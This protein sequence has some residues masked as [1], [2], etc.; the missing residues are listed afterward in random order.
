MI[1]AW[2][3]GESHAPT[4]LPPGHEGGNDSGA[5]MTISGR[6][7]NQRKWKSDAS[8]G[9][10]DQKISSMERVPNAKRS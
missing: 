1:D 3:A 6:L 7:V 5:D 10:C 4:L 2:V 9:P 8:P